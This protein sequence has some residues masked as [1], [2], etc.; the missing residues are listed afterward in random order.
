V[1][2]MSE[3]LMRY[4]VSREQQRADAVAAVLGRM[5]ERE[6]RL[7]REVAVMGYVRGRMSMPGALVNPPPMPSDTAVTREVVDAALAMPDLYP[8]LN[9]IAEGCPPEATEKGR[10]D[11]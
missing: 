4:L 1:I 8:V 10:D 3:D 2:K 6:Q 11:A 9:W 5:T 7:V